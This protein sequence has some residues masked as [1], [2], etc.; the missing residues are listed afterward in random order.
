MPVNTKQYVNT[1]DREIVKV[2]FEKWKDI[3]NE[4]AKLTSPKD[5]PKNA[6]ASYTASAMSS[7][8]AMRYIPQGGAVT[9]D[10][11]EEGHKKT[12]Y[13]EKYGLGIQF[14]EESYTDDLTGNVKK[15]GAT[16][17]KRGVVK[18]HTEFFD[19]YNN[20]FATETAWDGGYIFAAHTVLK[21]GGFGFGSSY[22]NYSATG[23]DL[24]ETSL[25]A[26]ME[27]FSTT[28][29]ESGMPSF[30]TPETL[31]VGTHL[32]WESGVLMNTANLVGSMDNDINTAN[33]KN[34]MMKYSKHVSRYIDE[35]SNQPWFLQAKKSDV[36]F[37]LWWVKKLKIQSS[38]HFDTDNHLVKATLRFYRFCLDPR[39]VYGSA[40]S[41]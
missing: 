8:G 21:D 40:G 18:Y 6:M 30:E 29:D 4:V 35:T 23:A 27:Y 33:P 2:V 31:I 10:L 12:V 1:I 19:L 17:A 7:V 13:P 34:G 32:D 41:A 28:I 39:G 26:A 22:T 14:T 9:F 25:Q 15:M 16:L 37:N 20:G 3:P 36:D 24:A 5:A 11:P 38:D